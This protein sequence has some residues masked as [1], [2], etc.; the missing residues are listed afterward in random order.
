LISNPAGGATA[1]SPTKLYPETLKVCSP[2]GVPEVLENEFKE[3]FAYTTGPLIADT[4]ILTSS[5]FQ[6]EAVDVPPKP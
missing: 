5:T 4:L 2:E 6:F 1:R 3:P